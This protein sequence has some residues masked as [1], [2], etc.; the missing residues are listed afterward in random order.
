[1]HVIVKKKDSR[2]HWVSEKKEEI[3][4]DMQNSAGERTNY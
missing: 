1:M 3:E 4:R 2:V